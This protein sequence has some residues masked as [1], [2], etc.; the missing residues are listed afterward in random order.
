MQV[1]RVRFDIIPTVLSLCMWG[2][3]VGKRISV[4][5]S[6]IAVWVCFV[7]FDHSVY[8]ALL[9]CMMAFHEC[10]HLIALKMC[11]AGDIKMTVSAF[12]A[13]IRY[14]L[15]FG[16]TV[17]RA[18]VALGGVFMNLFLGGVFLW[19]IENPICLYISVGNF[20]LAILNLMPIK[21]A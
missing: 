19:W 12:G 18:A 17:G 1:M 16:N 5:P 3:S 15:P 9:F 11:G 14:R 7:A 21:G 8:T 10:G 13:E 6:A 2:F 20:V 4:K